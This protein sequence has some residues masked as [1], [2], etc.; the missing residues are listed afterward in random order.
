LIKTLIESKFSL[1]KSK[2]YIYYYLIYISYQNELRL[3]SFLIFKTS[4]VHLLKITVH[5]SSEFFQ[6]KT[7]G[8][9]ALLFDSSTTNHYSRKFFSYGTPSGHTGSNNTGLKSL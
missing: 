5:Y 1:T 9:A 4:K 2:D 7:I 3:K 6:K 8:G